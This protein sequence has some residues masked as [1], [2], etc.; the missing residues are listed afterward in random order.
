MTRRARTVRRKSPPRPAIPS[1][2]TLLRLLRGAILAGIALVLLTP[3]VVM[4]DLFYPHAVGKAVWSRALIEILFALW[5]ALVLADPAARPPRSL[6]LVL[7]GIGAA[8]AFLAAAFGA[9]FG[10]SLWSSYARMQG[11]VDLLHWLA[12]FTVLLSVLRTPREW[13]L[14]LVLHLSAGTVL[15]LLVIAGSLGFDP[16]F[17]AAE[18]ERN[19]Q[20][21]G[22]PLG[23]P[24]F[25]G[26]YL[27]VNAILALGFA[28]AS[29]LRRDAAPAGR[30]RA[31]V[32]WG[33]VAA[34]HLW[35][36][37]L[38]GS[39]SAFVGLLAGLV[40][41]GAGL[42]ALAPRRRRRAALLA[43]GMVAVAVAAGLAV[44]DRGGVAARW[45]HHPAVQLFD[46]FDTDHPTVR[47]RLEAW[48]MS[49]AGFADRPLLGWGPENFD[50]VFG[51]HATGYGAAM[52]AH[53]R[54]HSTLFEVAA[55]AGAAG[56][57]A[58]L[59][60]WAAT[61][62]AVWRTARGLAEPMQVLA[63]FAGAALAAHFVQG[64]ASFDTVAS[65]M[66]HMLLLAFLAF[67]VASRRP[68]A[69]A[70]ALPG[71]AALRLRAVRGALFGGR[72]CRGPGR[73]RHDACDPRR[74]AGAACGDLERGVPRTF[75][76]RGGRLRAA[77]RR[78]APAALPQR[79]AVLGEAPSKPAQGRGPVPRHG[80]AR[81]G[82]GDR[83]RAPEL[84]GAARAR[85][86]LRPG[87]RFRPGLRP[88]GPGPSR[89]REGDGSPTPHP[90]S[91]ARPP[92][93]A[94]NPATG[95][96]APRAPLGR[97]GGGRL[98]PGAGGHRGRRLEAAA[99]Q[100]RRLAYGLR[101]A[102]L[103]RVRTPALRREGMRLAGPLQRL[104]QMASDPGPGRPRRREAAVRRGYAE[105]S[106]A[107]APAGV[108]YNEWRL[109]APPGMRLSRGGATSC[110]ADGFVPSIG[111]SVVIPCCDSAETL[112]PVLAA[113]EGQDWPPNLL[114][115]IVV[116][117]GSRPPLAPPAS[118]L[119][120]RVVR[121]EDRGFGLA[122]ARNAGARAARH[123]IL[124]FLDAD[125]VAA[126]GLVAAHARW[127]HAVADALTL[128]FCL[129]VSA[130][131]STPTISAARAPRRCSRTDRGIRPGTRTT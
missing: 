64:L 16:P 106:P 104:G 28:A 96:R 47:A 103:P 83:G 60:L 12:F 131:E 18:P 128:G 37:V 43:A 33:A 105:A 48:R 129:S 49:L 90:G 10:R 45:V 38:A 93:G 56:L 19:G 118:P 40:F 39:A 9:D 62:G 32:A 72:A 65:R 94:R 58:W 11:V 3:F 36:L 71:A 55:T 52:E 115:T 77:R 81:G 120:P 27:A 14:L 13:R 117:D 7:L 4:P 25:L 89:R 91:P 59:A 54:P 123:D 63:L 87:G 126:P 8:V 92:V 20:R 42:A 30:R 57:A 109:V 34:L 69:G 67:L 66:Q 5:A 100:L 26:A 46:K 85:A 41:A 22:G 23:S 78:A 121:L 114:E 76:A 122:R 84:A 2:E 130:A 15:V 97:R 95:G 112:A 44:V 75:P 113:L 99:L 102:A 107:P 31:A 24:L 98:P 110:P 6:L 88:A 61:F 82:G 127:H 73:A 53:D 70:A 111:V 125:I 35:G 124:V 101:P 17:Y 108:R 74:R 68:P 50:V 80:R 86:P 1:T 51:R 29:A 79:R 116:D 21:S 119:E